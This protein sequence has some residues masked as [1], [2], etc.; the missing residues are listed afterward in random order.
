MGAG[1]VRVAVIDVGSNTVRLLLAS[2]YG[3]QLR[4]IRE[5]KAWIGLGSDVA[6]CG[7]ISGPALAAV[8]A[9]VADFAAEARRAGCAKLEVLVASPGHRAANGSE[10]V[11]RLE[12]AARTGV[13]LLRRDEE[14][15][16]AF[17]PKS[18]GELAHT[19]ARH[20]SAVA[21]EFRPDLSHNS[22]TS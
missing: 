6:A 2:A 9:T 16:L 3:S 11:R 8:A 13:R 15:R 12:A 1:V 17:E 7:W 4:A 22:R 14:A 19:K 20:P 21:V 10:L 18:M 5:R